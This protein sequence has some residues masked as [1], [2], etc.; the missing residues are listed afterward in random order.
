MSD[1][2]EPQ[3]AANDNGRASSPRD[4]ARD[5]GKL[6]TS[7]HVEAGG[8]L[9]ISQRVQTSGRGDPQHTRWS[10]EGERAQRILG[11]GHA[12]GGEAR[13]CA[14]ALW[15]LHGQGARA[16][17]ALELAVVLC[18]TES[19]RAALSK[20]W[21][22]K[23]ERA[24][25]ALGVETIGRAVGWYQS[26][27]EAPGCAGQLG[28]LVSAAD[29]LHGSGGAWQRFEVMCKAEREKQVA[30]SREERRKGAA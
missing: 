9:P 10:A 20:R 12:E 17:G 1:T 18:L 19:E 27:S 4:A 7:G 11:R 24:L 2:T 3:E 25:A 5:I 23:S 15:L 22:H 6:A 26:A 29:A 30:L 8:A 28:A 16:I 21:G 14:L 13:R